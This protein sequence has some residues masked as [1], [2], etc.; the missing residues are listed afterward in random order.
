[1]VSFFDFTQKYVVKENKAHTTFAK[2]LSGAKA[3]FEKGDFT[4]RSWVKPS[5]TGYTVKVGKLEG[6][7]NVPTKA[8]VIALLDMAADAL[9]S[10]K[11]FQNAVESA[12]GEPLGEE[13]A[14][15]KPRKARTP[16]AAAVETD[17]LSIP[18]RPRS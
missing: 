5:G 8:E 2:G 17:V 1:M 13:P 4:R 11:E 16:K 6:I 15:K 9:Q 10:D 3:S 18:L 7:Y 14:I 12:Y